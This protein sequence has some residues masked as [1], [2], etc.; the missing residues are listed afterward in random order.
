M[1][2]HSKALELPSEDD[3]AIEAS[4]PGTSKAVTPDDVLPW[5]EVSKEQVEDGSKNCEQQGI[6]DNNEAPLNSIESTDEPAPSCETANHDL[7]LTEPPS[8]TEDIHEHAR[9]DLTEEA[10]HFQPV[11]STQMANDQAESDMN[12]VTYE[13]GETHVQ[14]GYT[15]EEGTEQ[16]TQAQL[17]QSN[18]DSH[19][20][21]N[22]DG[23][24]TVGTEEACR[25]ACAD[26]GAWANSETHQEKE[27]LEMTAGHPSSANSNSANSLCIEA[28]SPVETTTTF[29]AE[30][31]DDDGVKEPLKLTSSVREN[32]V[33]INLESQLLSSVPSQMKYINGVKA[34]EEPQV[35]PQNQTAT[36]SQEQPIE[37]TELSEDHDGNAQESVSDTL[38][39]EDRVA[40][41]PCT[42]MPCKIVDYVQS[43]EYGPAVEKQNGEDKEDQTNLLKSETEEVL[44]SEKENITKEDF[45]TRYAEFVGRILPGH[46]VYYA[47]KDQFGQEIPRGGTL[48][49]HVDAR[50]P[51]AVLWDTSNPSV[52]TKSATLGARSRRQPMKPQPSVNDDHL[53]PDS[54]TPSK[55]DKTLI[56]MQ[57]AENSDAKYDV[58]FM[59]DDAFL[60]R[61]MRSE[62]GEGDEENGDSDSDS[63]YES[64]ELYK[65]F[66]AKDHLAHLDDTS[67]HSKTAATKPTTGFTW[68]SGLKLCGCMRRSVK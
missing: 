5:D 66:L 13:S 18:P 67:A 20:N 39:T 21:N 53:F 52:R 35:I 41:Q 23:S 10:E 63:D 34:C 47:E 48:H 60:P 54:V 11:S 62:R 45:E 16:I 55:V 19:Q 29:D 58:P 49:R 37:S 50:S 8:R 9:L 42:E 3:P 61:R 24:E 32:D 56:G 65:S 4:P 7:N 26:N 2:E 59:D 64:G 46:D 44:L 33:E 31:R 15:A 6:D 68:L 57:T 38:L 14:N 17:D 40:A 12:F 27:E 28:S 30:V 1:E 25:N 43:K 51:Y 36:A 22:G